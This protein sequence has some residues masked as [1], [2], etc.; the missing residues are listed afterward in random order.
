MTRHFT[1]VFAMTMAV[2]LS[3]QSATWQDKVDPRLSLDEPSDVL[4]FLSAQADLDQA[5]ILDTRRDRGRLVCALLQETAARTQSSLRHEL[6]QDGLAYRHFWICNAIAVPEAS[7]ALLTTLAQRDD[8][9]RIVPDPL[10]ALVRPDP[11]ASISAGSAS[12]TIPWN[13]DQ[14]GAPDVWAT[15]NTGQAAV[16]GILDSGCDWQHPAVRD[17]YR[18]W[19]GDGVDHDYNWHD[20]V[21]ESDRP[22]GPDSPE[23]CDDLGH[24]THILGTAVGDDGQ[25]MQIGVAPGARWIACRCLDGAWSSPSMFFEG[26][27]WMMAPRPVGGGPGDPDRAPDVVTTAWY[28]PPPICSTWDMLL[29]AVAALRAAGIMVVGTAG[30]DGPGC[31]SIMFPPAIYDETTTIGVTD[32]ADGITSFSGRGPVVTEQGT[33]IKP[34]LSA[35]GVN[36]L[37]CLPDGDYSIWSGGAMANAHGAGAV[38]LVVTAL[39]ALAGNPDAIEARLNAT[40]VMLTSNQCGDG[41]AVPNNVYGHG[42]LD[43]AAACDEITAIHPSARAVLHL[44]PNEPNPF[45]PRTTLVYELEQSGTVDLHIYDLAGKLIR[46]LKHGAWQT[47]GQHRVLWDGRDDRGCDVAAG[48]YLSSLQSGETRAMGRMALI[49]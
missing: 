30:G 3:A 39:P 29:P 43:V 24:G 32:Q 21:H 12:R 6:E 22:C 10:V 8:V 27:E 23:P 17:Q 7:P 41:A 13:I 34:D 15:G 1:L 37:S 11:S 44:L 35:P 18:G 14:I 25:G 45:N 46:V 16:V 2:T 42:R 9:A 33:L 5:R 4:I 31:D 20:A 49:R 38:A 26:F 36:I 48:V 40:A 47:A 19:T 28:C